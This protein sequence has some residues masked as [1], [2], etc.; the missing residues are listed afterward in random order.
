M[1]K[2]QSTTAV[3]AGATGLVG[4]QLVRQLL[5]HPAYRQVI[6]LVRRDMGLSHPKLV[7]KLISFDRLGEEV[8]SE[9]LKQADV[10]CTLGTTIKQAGSQEAF[11]KVDYT[12]P[13]E[14][15][16]AARKYGAAK[17]IVVTAMASSD[18]SKLFYNRVKGELERELI[19]LSLPRLVILRPSFMLGNRDKKRLGEK[20]G[21]IMFQFLRPF[22]VGPFS[23][24]K[25]VHS[26]SVAWVM[27]DASLRTGPKLE[28]I[29]SNDIAQRA[30][31]HHSKSGSGRSSAVH[32]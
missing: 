24:Y 4:Q 9:I 8:G 19:R 15:G 26:K 1:S 30:A 13:L 25:A 21:I 2:K 16:R 5:E 28:V 27:V 7:Q 32:Q 12:Y 14:L 11:R 31:R 6:V 29:E 22:M 10:F 3:V 17:M 18:K 23:Q 20:M